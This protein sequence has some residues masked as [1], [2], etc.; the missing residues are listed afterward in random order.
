MWWALTSS[1]QDSFI[2]IIKWKNNDDE[3]ERH[4]SPGV[5]EITQSGVIRLN[6][7]IIAMARAGDVVEVKEGKIFV[8]QTVI[9]RDKNEDS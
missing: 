8:N 5:F 7:T 3:I 1:H 2:M 9:W 6:S 4:E